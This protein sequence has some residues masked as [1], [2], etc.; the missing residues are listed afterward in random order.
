MR[1]FVKSRRA[2]VGI[3]IVLVV[4]LLGTATGMAVSYRSQR[5]TAQAKAASFH[6]SL[7]RTRGSLAAAQ[8]R[9]DQLS[10]DLSSARSDLDEANSRATVKNT[11]IDGL[12]TCIAALVNLLDTVSVS[13][14]TLNPYLLDTVNPT[15]IANQCAE[16]IRDGAAA[17]LN[18]G[19][20][21]AASS[22]STRS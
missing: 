15:A 21:G 14:Q 22:A 6:R 1:D 16:A 8:Q 20:G 4:A 11:A 9:N 7:N 2:R 12:D 3:T 19:D 10:S 17:Q 18:T 5:D 13:L